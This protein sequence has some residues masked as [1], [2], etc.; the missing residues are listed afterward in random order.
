MPEEARENA[1][2]EP[3][4]GGSVELAQDDGLDESDDWA[5]DQPR[6]WRAEWAPKGGQIVVGAHNVEF[7]DES[8]S[9]RYVIPDR[10]PYR[11]LLDFVVATDLDEL[12][13]E[14]G[15]GGRLRRLSAAVVAD[16][17]AHVDDEV[18]EPVDAS[19]AS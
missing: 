17:R 2:D 4:D 13:T 10:K 7:P 5:A 8:I 19:P 14:L 18:E 15:A 11:D 3:V 1:P 6:P 16:R 12:V 9:R